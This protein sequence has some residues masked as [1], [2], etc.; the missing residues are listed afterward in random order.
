MDVFKHVELNGIL[1][2][3]VAHALIGVSLIW[4]K[5]LLRKP[6]MQDI[7]SYVFWLGAISI[8]GLAL[9]PFGAKYPGFKL[10]ALAITAGLLD[11]VASYFYYAALQQGEASEELAAMGGFAPVATAALSLPFLHAAFGSSVLGFALMSA[12]GFLMFL[13]EKQPL[14][15][16]LPHVVLASIGFGLTNVLQKIVFNGTNFVSGYVFFTIGTTIGASALLLRPSWRKHVFENSE[17]APPSS[18]AWYMVNRIMAGVGSFLVV[19]AV[20]RTA[21]STVEAISGVRY[22]IIFALAY[23]ITEWKPDWFHEDFSRDVLIVKSIATALIVAGVVIAGL[24]G[25]VGSSGPQ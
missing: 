19:L 11:L 17:K 9:L 16:V 7:V 18:K 2:A 25:G 24:T 12:G 10:T 6:A 1:L 21:P 13:A 3:I 14:R 8:F 15:K 23:A 5:V 22:V 4:D 20:S